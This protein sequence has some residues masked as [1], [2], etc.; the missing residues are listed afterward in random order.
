M[1]KF[2]LSL[3][4]GFIANNLVGTLV[5]M[6]IV[7]PLTH[8]LMSEFERKE[9]ELEMPSLLIGYFVLTLIMVLAYPYFNLKSSWLKKGTIWGLIAGGMSFVSI[10]LIISGWS[11]FPPKAM[12][13]SGI[14]DMTSTVVTGIVIAYIYRKDRIM[15][16]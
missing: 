6:F 8:D 16:S 2:S 12:L 7:Q 1:K 10:Y 4:L 11:I 15:E 3:L 14:I 13:I 5:A 9:G